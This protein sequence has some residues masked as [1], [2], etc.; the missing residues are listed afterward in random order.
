M[1]WVISYQPSRSFRLLVV[2]AS[3]PGTDDQFG[4]GLP[5]M[6]HTKMH[7]VTSPSTETETS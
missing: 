2:I 7:Q 4:R 3:L 6:I 5:E 1:R